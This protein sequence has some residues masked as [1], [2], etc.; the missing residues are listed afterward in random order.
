MSECHAGLTAVEERE[1]NIGKADGSLEPKCPIRVLP[2]PQE[3]ACLS[4]LVML[5]DSCRVTGGKHG[6]SSNT[7]MDFRMQ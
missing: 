2:L 5:R 6:L 1:G 3:Q 7:E 4:I